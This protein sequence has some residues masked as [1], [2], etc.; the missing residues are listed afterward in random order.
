MNFKFYKNPVP[1]IVIDQFFTPE[2]YQKVWNEIMFLSPKMRTPDETGTAKS[3]RGFLKKGVGVF[4]EGFYNNPRD[5]DIFIYCKKIFDQVNVE[6]ISSSNLFFK[7][8]QFVNVTDSALVQ[9]YKNGDFYQPHKDNSLYTA[10]TLVHKEPKQ[11]NGGDFYFSES[12]HVVELYSNQTIIFPS[13]A[14]HGVSE[15]KL[16]SNEIEDARFTISQLLYLAPK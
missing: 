2:E 5:S 13:F 7:P 1:H 14:E 4:L 3:P 8:F 10:V 16:L 11:Y 15:V 6:K 12:N 9:M